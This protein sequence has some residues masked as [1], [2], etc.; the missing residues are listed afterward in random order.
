MEYL[1]AVV[2]EGHFGR[3]AA[4]LHVSASAL[5]QQIRKLE[6]QL[7]VTLLDRSVHPVRA[8][9]EGSEIIPAAR[10]ALA[11][12][13]DARAVALQVARR[14]AGKMRIGFVLGF[15]GHLTRPILDG[16]AVAQPG[17]TVDL[18]ELTFS[19]QVDAVVRHDIDACF[20]RV[21]FRTDDRVRIEHVLD[22][23]R[24]VALPAS[25]P[26]AGRSEISISELG[27][28]PCL[29]YDDGRIDPDFTRWWAAD[30]R[31]DGSSAPPGPVGQSITEFTEHVVRG[32]GI[33]FTTPALAD[34]VRRSDMVFVPVP[35]IAASQAFLCTRARD[36]SPG[37]QALR[38]ITRDVAARS[39]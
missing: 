3:A 25:H 8:T 35:D 37:V 39:R 11:A 14:R 6:D 18:V 30:P 16:I 22:E 7:Q 29:R 17:L 1:V 15:L 20:V 31:P 12:A 9:E 13:E 19:D 5:S 2:D 28:E 27:E 33:F 21:P 36:R 32:H 24:L 34:Q 26:L 38:R 23:G 4:A 10:A